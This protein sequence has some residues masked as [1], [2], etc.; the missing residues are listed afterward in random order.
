MP[1]LAAELV[2]ALEMFWTTQALAEGRRRT[3]A[4]LDQG[5][6]IPAALRAALL[7]I[8]GGT[9]ILSENNQAAGEPSYHEA[10]D[11]Y[12]ELGD[13]RGEAKILMRLAVH[14]GTRGQADEARRLIALVRTMT[15]GLDLPV[16]ETQSLSTLASLAE[17][18]GALEDAYALYEQSADV[19]A[20]CGF[21][22]WETWQR[23][24]VAEIGL[25]LGRYDAAEAAARTALEKSWEHGDRR[26]ALY[27]L[28]LLARSAQERGDPA[29]A[30]RLWGAV[31]A[32]DELGDIL[33]S[34]HEFT[35]LIAALRSTSDPELASGIDLGKTAS[36]AEAVAL[37]LAPP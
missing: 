10:I 6:V 3:R 28:G 17:R 26:T 36:L 13:V 31:I 24:G 4:L 12:R 15:D 35:R 16:L 19:A 2:K 8:H 33:T 18:D 1:V 32:E 14:A 5:S 9:I 23:N 20:A 37:A 21:T 11:L 29:R 7:T 27:A 25:R 22:V 30:G 34:D